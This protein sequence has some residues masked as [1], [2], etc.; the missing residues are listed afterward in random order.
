MRK[1]KYNEGYGFNMVPRGNKY[2]TGEL[3]GGVVS[4]NIKNIFKDENA[5]SNATLRRY[6]K[7][8]GKIKR[9]KKGIET[10]RSFLKRLG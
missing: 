3:F 5:Q 8:Y 9:D 6:N 4:S 10:N 7:T 2:T 1:K